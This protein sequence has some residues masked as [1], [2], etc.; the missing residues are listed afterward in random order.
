MKAIETNQ[1]TKFYGKSRGITN[2][3]LSVEEGDFFG[4]IGPNGAG[5]STTIR[6]LLGLIFPTSGSAAVLGKSIL[7]NRIEILSQVG[8][9]PSEAM[10][11]SGMRV[12]DILSYSA[13]LHQKDC[14]EEAGKLC[15]RLELDISRRV[16]ELSLGN[17]KKV[18]IV[19]ALQHKPKLYILDEPTSGLDPLMQKEFYELLTER[20]QEGATVFL[21]SHVLSEISRYCKHAAVI[22]DGKI[23]AS[24]SVEKLGH[25]GVKRVTLQ[26]AERVPEIPDAKNI[27][28]E[29]GS[30][31]FL[32]SG[33]P[34]QLLTSLADLSFEDFT[35]TDPDLEE[36]FMHY[37][38]KEEN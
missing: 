21:S 23:L 24:D 38:V 20:N 15:E 8:Y 3:N 33:S 5:K 30:V 22:R 26:S 12:R 27:T 34:K 37:Y 17:R 2:V 16:D 29:N 32:Y 18:G 28:V 31:S 7:Q 19:C 36:V 13:K 14:K 11:Y 1:L 35:V 4:F 6:T 10:F 25:T 9:L